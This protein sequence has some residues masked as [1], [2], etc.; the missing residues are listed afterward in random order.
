MNYTLTV[1]PRKEVRN[2]GGGQVGD[3]T[4]DGKISTVN[5]GDDGSNFLVLLHE[6]FEAELCRRAGITDAQVTKWDK[7]NPDRDPGIC[8][9]CPYTAQHG[10]AMILER[11][12]ADLMGISFEAHEKRIEA[13]SGGK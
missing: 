7:K 9:D 13:A 3:W 1:V 5:I 10:G 4:E 2:S 11:V 12:A 6:L 8:S